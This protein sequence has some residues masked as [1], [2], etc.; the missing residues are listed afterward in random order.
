[1]SSTRSHRAGRLGLAVIAA[2]SVIG[3]SPYGVLP[4]AAAAGSSVTKSKTV[5]RIYLDNGKKKVVD[6][7]TV[8]LTVD[9]T[10]NLRSLQQIQVSWSGAHVTGG[11]A[12]DPNSDAALNEEYSFD[13]FE[14][15]GVD[16]TKVPKKDRISPDTCWTQFADERFVDSFSGVPAWQ[17]DM[18]AP[19]NERAASVYAM[20]VKKQPKSCSNQL[21]GVAAQR[22]VP[23]V[24]ADGKR[25]P[26]GPDGC[27]GLAPEA[28]PENLSSLTLPSNETFGVT[29]TQGRGQAL[30]DV[31][32]AEDHASLGCSKSVPC[33]L[34]AVPIEGISCDAAGAKLPAKDRPQGADADDAKQ[35]CETAGTFKPGEQLSNIEASGSAAV[36]GALWW[37]AS[38]WRNRISVPLTF[39][40]ADNICDVVGHQTPQDVYGTELMV[41]AMTQ[42][43]PH[44]CLNPKLFDLKHV[45]TPE[46]EARTLLNAGGIQAAITSDPPTAGFVKPVVQAPVAITGFGIAYDVDGEDGQPVGHLNLDARLLAK[47]LTESYPAQQIVKSAYPA[48]A[49]GTETLSNNPLNITQDPEFQA[50]NPGIPTTTAN[51]AATLLTVSNG[52]DLMQALTSYINSDAEARAFMDGQPDPWGMRVNPFYEGMTL[53]VSTWP[54]LDTFEPLD[55]YQLG[56]NDC[57]YADPV[58]YLPQVA[59]PQASLFNIS[60]DMQF[61]I[62][63][64]QTK[65][66]LPSP[67]PGDLTGAKLVADG[68]QIPG[69]RF[70]LGTVSLG[71]AEREGLHLASL[72]ANSPADSGSKFSGPAGRT[73][74]APTGTGMRAASRLLKPDAKTGAW[75][76]PYTAIR[77][78][79]KAAAAYPGT[80]V[81]YADIP[82]TGLSA[83]QARDY[84]DFLRF[85]AHAGQQQGA[86]Q[87][88]LPA[89]YLPMTAANGAGDL[90]RYTNCAANDVQSQSGKLPSLTG[91]ACPSRGGGGGGGSSPPPSQGGTGTSPSGGSTGGSAPAPPP[92]PTT[93][94]VTQPSNP[95]PAPVV[96]TTAAALGITPMVSSGFAHAFGTMLILIVLI[97]A[98]TAAF[99]RALVPV[100]RRGRLDP[101]TRPGIA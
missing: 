26:G 75:P 22:W 19:R 68:R 40:P 10:T 70:M 17:S 97:A 57:L 63:Q 53:P 5:E 46:P 92:A 94:T 24:G 23:Y 74:V 64:S 38:N 49:D 89:G 35:E 81:V 80:M 91:P 12:N 25:Y 65:C 1:M 32:T 54:V 28:T 4:Q 51:A 99:V 61:A 36:D 67:N 82:T 9:D 18:F 20:R 101:A 90:V 30:F 11:V 66:V 6:K 14:C 33:S 42:W 41:Q 27:A 47:L 96:A 3:L 43:A 55:S 87:G 78:H 60:Q 85:A 21:I 34:V 2:G 98:G 50:L 13:L 15:R 45:Q 62:A 16:S 71:D 29:N 77:S 69:H 100:R 58:P 72:Q 93:P 48:S 8:H 88:D 44:F 37:S 7:R 56:L 79:A 83:S 84:A 39:A 31:F 59:S 76:I 52:S 73:F 95:E 86:S